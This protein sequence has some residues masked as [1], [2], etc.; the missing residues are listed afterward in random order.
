[1]NVDGESELPSNDEIDRVVGI[2]GSLPDLTMQEDITTRLTQVIAAESASRSAAA[3]SLRP[4][5]PAGRPSQPASQPSPSTAVAPLFYA[6][7]GIAAV[8]RAWRW[9][10][11]RAQS[12][13]AGRTA[14]IA[15]T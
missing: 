3:A 5:T 1:M 12:D 15:P 8:G 9:S 10:S 2:L 13:T 14:P 6:A 4:C 11:I 7:A